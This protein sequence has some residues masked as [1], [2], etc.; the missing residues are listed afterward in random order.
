MKKNKK[1]FYS[2]LLILLLIAMTITIVLIIKKYG[3][4]IEVEKE[5]KEVVEIFNQAEQK[6]DE[7]G[8]GLVEY[9]GYKVIGIIKIPKID[10]EYPI[11]EKTTKESMLISISRFWGGE[12][13]D[14]GNVS[15]AGHNNK[16]LTMFGKNK[17]LKKDDSI[18]LTGLD[19][20]TI[21]YKI[22]DIFLTD[23]NDVTILQTTDKTKR[24]VT[25]IT[26]S[27]GHE[28]RLIVKAREII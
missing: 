2:I 20:K 6:K 15:L 8:L 23:P 22:Y 17:F 28:N 9:K 12:I 5:N 25:L 3:S 26:C 27:K 14:Y 10:L 11:L 7:E 4:Q 18:F 1:I 13:N 16:T 19:N 21:E 24:E